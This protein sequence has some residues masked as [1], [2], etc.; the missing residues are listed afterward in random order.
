VTRLEL[1]DVAVAPPGAP[2]AVLEGF[3]LELRGGEWV[4]LGGP[5]GCG[6]TTLLLVAAGLREPRSGERRIVADP[7]PP[8]FSTVLQDPSA[9]LFEATVADEIA[10]SSINLGRPSTEVADEVRRY[11]E[12]LGL[13]EDLARDPRTLSAGRQQLVLIAAALAPRP[14]FLIADE[15]GAHLDFESRDRV[16]RVI[17]SEVERGMGV[18]WATQSDDEHRAADRRVMLGESHSLPPRGMPAVPARGGEP[19]LTIEIEP[20]AATDGP[21]VRTSRRLEI[22]IGRA[23][24]V[25]LTGPNGVGKSVLLSAAVGLIDCPQLRR[26]GK[27][28]GPP[29]LVAQYP[30]RQIFEDSVGREVRFAAVQRGVAPAEAMSLARREFEALGMADG[31]LERRTWDLSAG[32]KRLVLL[33]SALV[34]P[35]SLLALDEPTAGLDPGRRASVAEAVRRRA[36]NTPVLVASQDLGWLDSLGAEF[37][38]LTGA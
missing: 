31:F 19:A 36:A 13:S 38:T 10:L 35:A 17:R 20:A 21:R 15:P 6:K 18:L 12:C 26:I 23:G 9:Q 7:S 14:D 34:S 5:N 8:V 25:A 32:E 2:S 1:R 37:Q 24:V 4:S 29:L 27:L 33:V 28:S 3:S 11:G 22:R 30:E 16:L